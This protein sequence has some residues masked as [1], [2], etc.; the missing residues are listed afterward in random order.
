[1]FRQSIAPDAIGMNFHATR[2]DDVAKMTG[3]ARG[4]RMRVNALVETTRAQLAI[5]SSFCPGAR[6]CCSASANAQT[7]V[8]KR[9]S[10]GVEGNDRCH[11]APCFGTKNEAWGTDGFTNYL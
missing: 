6:C 9:Y 11:R 3:A 5:D 1:M 8:L 4:Y 10:G 2:A 7:C